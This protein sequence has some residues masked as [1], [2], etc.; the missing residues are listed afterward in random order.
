LQKYAPHGI[1][2]G[3]IAAIHASINAVALTDSSNDN[4]ENNNNNA[5]YSFCGKLANPDPKDLLP[6]AISGNII[7]LFVGSKKC[8]KSYTRQGR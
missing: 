5:K 7:A 6:H 1:G 3:S 4:K 8:Q 2:N